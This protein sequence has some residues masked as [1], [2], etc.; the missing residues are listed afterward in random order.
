MQ[1]DA[2]FDGP[3]KGLS[4]A[5]TRAAFLIALGEGNST[6]ADALGIDRSTVWR[7]GRLE[8]FEAAVNTL[9]AD[10]KAEVERGALARVQRAY[11]TLDGLLA[12][13]DERVRLRAALSILDRA[14]AAEVG[15]ADANRIVRRDAEKLVGDTAHLMRVFALMKDL[16]DD[17]DH[18]DAEE[19]AVY[20]ARRLEALG[21]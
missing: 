4:P 7:W 11:R 15:F 20:V 13:Q 6:V 14:E 9:L 18:P 2:T 21:L 8:T 10:A 17:P 1:P 5:Q 19:R 16:N 3:F 12:S